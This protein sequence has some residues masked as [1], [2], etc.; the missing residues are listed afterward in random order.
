MK[1]ILL[2]L[3]GI[4]LCLQQ[5]HAQQQ[6]QTWTEDFDGASPP[7]GWTVSPVGSWQPNTTYHQPGSSTT[8]PQ[9]YRGKVPNLV[10]DSILLETPIYDFQSTGLSFVLLRFSHICKV[11][12]V[13]TVRLEYR[14][15]MGA[16][17]GPWLPVPNYAYM[18]SAA[19]Y[20]P[21]INFNSASYTSWQPSDSLAS[22]NQSWWKEELFDLT[23]LVGYYQA[24]FRFIIKRGNIKGTQV[25]YG[26]LIDNVEIIGTENE[27]YPPVVQFQEGYPKDTV[28]STGAYKINAK[29]MTQTAAPIEQPYLK[30]VATRNGVHVETD[31]ILMENISGDS[32]WSATIKQFIQG[33]DITYSIYGVD[34]YGNSSNAVTT[35]YIR[36]P[37]GAS[38]GSVIIGD[39]ESDLA[40]SVLPYF[41][42]VYYTYG[43]SRSLY[44]REEVYPQRQEGLIRSIYYDNTETGTSTVDSLSMYVKATDD[45]EISVSSYVDPVL[46]GAT[47]VWGKATGSV[48]GTGWIEFEF[49]QPFYLPLGKNLMIYWM[50][51]DATYDG[52]GDPYWRCNITPFN[53]SVSAYENSPAVFLPAAYTELTM[54][55]PNIKIDMDAL[56]GTD[57]SAGLVSIDIPS[58]V[59][60][61]PT[62]QVPLTVTIRNKGHAD[63]SS[64]VISYSI[65]GSP[66]VD[67]NWS[68]TT[69]V[70][71]D[72]NTRATIGHYTPKMNGDDTLLIWISMPNGVADIIPYDDTL[73]RI[74]Y[75]TV[76]LQVAFVTFPGDTVYATG[77]HDVTVSIKSLSGAQLP[78]I[79]KMNIEAD[80]LG[81]VS[82]D[83]LTMV[84]DNG[85]D[86]WKVQIPAH[87]LETDVR[88]SID[89]TDVL[90]NE[91]SVAERYYIKTLTEVMTTGHFYYSPQ[92]SGTGGGSYGGGVLVIDPSQPYSWSRNLYLANSLFNI[93]PSKPTPVTA[94]GFK[95][96]DLGPQR[97]IKV[98]LKATTETSHTSTNYIDA[99]ADGATLV[100]DGVID[101]LPDYVFT[102]GAPRTQ[103]TEVQFQKQFIL[104]PN[105]NLMVYI[106]DS[107]GTAGYGWIS[108]MNASQQGGSFNVGGT[109]R[110]GSQGSPVVT[111]FGTGPF[112][113][114]DSVSVTVNAFISPRQA[115][116]QFTNPMDVEIEIKN[117]GYRMLDSCRVGWSLNGIPQNAFT[118]YGPLYESFIDVI[119]LGEYTATTGATDV[120][121]AWV[122]MPNGQ[123]DPV[124][125]DDTLE[126]II[127][128]CTGMLSGVQQVG[129]NAPYYKTVKGALIALEQCGISGKVI[130][131]LESGTYNEGVVFSEKLASGMTGGDT[132]LLRSQ[133]GNANNVKIYPLSGPGIK[134]NGSINNLIIENITIDATRSNAHGIEFAGKCTNVVIQN[135]EIVA[136]PASSSSVC[137]IYRAGEGLDRVAIKNNLIE[138]GNSGI[139]LQG[140]GSRNLIT[141]ISIENNRIQ[142]H[143]EHGIYS[144]YCD[145]SISYN[146]ILSSESSLSTEAGTTWYGIYSRY[147]G[148]PVVGN[149]IRMRG[150]YITDPHGIYTYYYYPSY[151]SLSGG[152]GLVA[153]NEIITGTTSTYCAAIYIGYECRADYLHN[154]IYVKGSGATRGIYIT[155]NASSQLRIEKN[156]IVMESA[157]AYPV[158]LS[159]TE[160][161]RLYDI[162][163]NN[164]YGNYLGYLGTGISSF[165]IW[166]QILPNDKGSRR[167]LPSFVNINQSLDLS[168]TDGLICERDP[169]AMTTINRESRMRRTV[170]GAYG[171]GL[172]DGYDL[173][174]TLFTAPAYDPCVP[175]N[176]PVKVII[177]NN[178]STNHDFAVNPITLHLHVTGLSGIIP[179]FDTTIVINRGTLGLFGTEEVTFT[180]QLN[181]SLP[182]DYYLTAWIGNHSDS[183]NKNDT[184]KNSYTVTKIVLPLDEDFST[185]I[186]GLF[187]IAGNTS[188]QW[189]L[190]TK[191]IGA[192]SNITPGHGT[193]MLVFNGS[194]GSYTELKTLK[195]D[196]QNVLSPTL[197][198]WYFHDTIAGEDYLD[199]YITMDGE[200][201]VPALSLLKQ[202]AVY[203]WKSYIVDLSP[204]T[205]G[206]CV[207]IVFESM[208]MSGTNVSQYID[209]IR[210][211]AQQDIV[212]EEIITSQL[213]ACDL[214]N[215]EWKV[216]LSNLSDILLS[217]RDTPTDIIFEITGT[218]HRFT[219]TLDTGYLERF[220]SDTITLTSSFD[221]M[222]GT[223]NV[224][225]YFS[226]ALDENPLND[227]LRATIV[228]NPKVKITTHKLSGED[229]NC[230]ATGA[231]ALQSVTI[232]NIGN[233]VL[234][235]INLVLQV[236][237]GSNISAP[238]SIVR[239]PLPV[240]NVAP[241]QSFDHEFYNGYVVPGTP[242][243][244]VLVTAHLSCDSAM[245][246]NA[247][248]VNECVDM[249]N[250]TFL[251][252]DK[253]SG[254]IDSIGS[255]INMEV[256]LENRS[257]VTSFSN[258][259]IH[260]RVKDSKGTVVASLSET[261][262]GTIDPLSPEY[263][264][265][266]TPYTVP[267]DSVYYIT[268][269][270]D[271]QAK[272][273]YQQDDTIQT[274]RTT[275]YKVGIESIDPPKISM[276]QNI[277]NPANNNTI[278]KYNIPESGEVTFR[279]HSM[280]GQLLHNKT[281]QSEGGTNTIEINTS[282]LSAGIYMYSMEYKGQ[283]IVKR[284][285]IKR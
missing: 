232:E 36:T 178:G 23:H 111:R 165:S 51:E 219:H 20:N 158:Y 137:G 275:D 47:L 151:G 15:N 96:T 127:S 188:S 40:S 185:G 209:R 194:K 113:Y 230:L 71:W 19:N 64:A 26:W 141:N 1:R 81:T 31:S 174:L 210:V 97:D 269:F 110:S 123:V 277:P 177:G 115:D 3:T 157:A 149:K 273:N 18:G 142:N 154:S 285:S 276:E 25:Y 121:T 264:T 95:A 176:V 175:S 183:D 187:S 131:E 220:S 211:T 72:F 199:V 8:N 126:L 136:T 282:T 259:A 260:A 86:L 164:L 116:V 92:D 166:E 128:G 237:T 206:S 76:D 214:Q 279:I 225:A 186:P 37:S 265:F 284:M 56:P 91:F 267:D 124:T 148:G 89:F 226:T 189:A 146:T 30:Y 145:A 70:P 195:I 107:T 63:L 133:S 272:D 207:N 87:R 9:S 201:Y 171:R 233:M 93:N 21:I 49:H 263:H 167:V 112:L 80:N 172:P 68:A 216:V 161:L 65:N 156:S 2:I 29:V 270:I 38:S 34:G 271:K 134:I 229:I 39:E 241:G 55:R 179:P 120:I 119:K 24:Q 5:G 59:T 82:R 138:G 122:S 170:M 243:Y 98:Y 168:G 204:Y 27:A 48:S 103:W 132:I 12:P 280:N 246:N 250:L 60:T 261:I 109:A 205:S 52:T 192:D 247:S 139:Y 163:N 45:M 212:I 234:P 227:T 69:P 16:V 117:V 150:T 258:I 33:T 11:S 182:D 61:S 193:S 240:R 181:V 169:F 108:W 266:S 213:S 10:G 248:A 74:V 4:L 32:L 251:S 105:H 17:M 35:Y 88:C 203:G 106:Y 217:Y 253:P 14:V 283:R 198:F 242:T 78:S 256:T 281:V 162:K 254:Q 84:H 239:E 180:N 223:Y 104:P 153:N 99:V 238:Y 143:Y 268:V 135:C 58:P 94:I 231:V 7:A 75:G 235:N 262:S 125:H 218:S 152:Y 196:L 129:P 173:A 43:W 160:Y 155:S 252:I 255:N 184:V 66:P 221:F 54:L 249:D 159:S 190:A 90:G 73:T 257:D 67:Y 100:Y 144:Y 236:D 118:Y 46:D 85:V 83:T 200:N 102:S 222:P 130:L 244:Q 79:V 274:K 278:I 28:Y 228:I 22:P 140:D 202:D 42:Y 208:S 62:H 77:P 53:S 41:S 191:G 215:K 197:E 50:K 147:S 114:E 245:V 224:I 101:I 57:N 13:D 44:L 6:R